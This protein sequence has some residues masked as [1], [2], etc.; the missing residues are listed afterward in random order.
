[1][2]CEGVA[3]GSECVAAGN[4]CRVRVLCERSRHARTAFAGFLHPRRLRDV[5]LLTARRRQRR[6]IW[7]LRRLAVRGLKLGDA[8]QQRL[9]LRHQL[10][11]VHREFTVLPQQLQRL[12]VVSER[13]NLLQ[14]HTSLNQLASKSSTR[15]TRVKPPQ[16]G[17]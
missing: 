8:G 5:P 3:D 6:V 10:S 1:M 4:A 7:R 2:G 16:R 9:V 12:H 15:H 17:K 14:R 13:I 11:D